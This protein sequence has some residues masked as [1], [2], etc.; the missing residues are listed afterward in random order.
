[1]LVLIDIFHIELVRFLVLAHL[2]FSTSSCAVDL[3]LGSFVAAL[4]WINCDEVL[5]WP[6]ATL[7]SLYNLALVQS[8]SNFL[9]EV[10]VCDARAQEILFR[11]RTVFIVLAISCR[12]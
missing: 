7:I 9:F 11:I 10:C 12:T 5:L 4:S 3:L 1:M 2:T 6:D 8:P